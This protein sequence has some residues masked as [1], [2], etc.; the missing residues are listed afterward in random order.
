MPRSRRPAN[1]L[2]T[3]FALFTTII[4]I[5]GVAGVAFLTSLQRTNVP[6]PSSGIELSSATTTIGSEPEILLANDSSLTVLALGGSVQRFTP[7]EFSTRVPE[8]F[9]PMEG[10]D[11]AN[12]S[13]RYFSLD[14]TTKQPQ[15]LLSPDRRYLARIGQPKSDGASVIE[16]WQVNEQPRPIVLRVD[17]QTVREGILLGWAD[18]KTLFVS[19]TRNGNRAIFSVNISG[20]VEQIVALSDAT[21]WVQ[22]SGRAVWYV[23]AQPGE[24][25]ESDPKPPSELHRVTLKGDERVEIDDASVFQGVVSDIFGHVAFRMGDGSAFAMRIGDASSRKPLDKRQPLLFLPDGRLLLRDG[26]DLW[27]FDPGTSV[28]KKIGTLPEGQVEVYLMPIRLDELKKT[29]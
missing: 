24:G 8:P 25:I 16:T 20:S 7:T 13:P 5:V 26:F 4:I 3:F 22:G 18:S 28:A 19:G 21:I 14:R 10:V 11:A 27:T 17:G 1:Q 12:G 29:P 9:R 2:Q 23:T 15:P 6:T